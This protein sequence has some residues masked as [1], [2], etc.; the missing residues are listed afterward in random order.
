MIKSL[1]IISLILTS[2]FSKEFKVASY[3]VENLFDLNHDKTEYKQYIP[4]KNYWNKKAYRN[5]LNNI[6]K[7]IKQLNADI[8][9]LQEI[10]SKQAL[11]DLNKLTKYKYHH[12]LKN[13]QSA[14][15]QAILSKYPIID[16]KRVKIK[17]YDRNNR[18]ILRATININGK[19]LIVYVNHWRSKRAA[20]SKR[21]PY[22]SSLQDDIK[23][24]SKNDDYIILGDLNANY[25]EFE[26]FR[27]DKKLN[28]THGITAINQVLNTSLDGNLIT[29]NKIQNTSKTN[30]HYNL[31]L[32]LSK[33]DRFSSVFKRD[34]N[35]PDNIIISKSLFDNKNISYVNN[36]FRVFKPKYLYKNNYV[37]RWKLKKASGYSDHLPIYASFSTKKQNYTF[38]E[39][40]HEKASIKKLYTIN[41]INHPIYINDIV[42]VYKAKKVAIIQKDKDRAILVYN[43]PK[44]LKEGYSYNI[45]VKKVDR[46]HGLKEIKDMAIIKVNSFYKDYKKFYKDSTIDFFDLN[47]QNYILKDIKGVYKK[48]YLYFDKDKRIKVYFKKGIKKPSFGEFI[49]IK[50]GHL[51]IYKSNIQ[52]IIYHKSDIL[53]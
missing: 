38:K 19:H 44:E 27:Y 29:K 32:E 49:T 31:W 28:N 52:I 39:I 11:K 4:Y 45:K 17:K 1:F 8:I 51:A 48:G 21:I 15:G 37:K 30:I 41:T 46:Y 23:S 50:L 18:P 2:L 14:V 22:A 9:G 7:V 42:V 5:K 36:S 25:N 34:K 3:N 20:E 24:L 13:K 26:T 43:P 16:T 53:Y 47:N 10:E 35:T 40:K 12:F 6:A 33:K